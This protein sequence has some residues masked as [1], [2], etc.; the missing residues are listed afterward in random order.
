[1]LTVIIVLVLVAALTFIL[2]KK[3]KTADAN[4]T[5]IPDVIETK[6]EIVIAEVKEKAKKA[7]PKK[8]AAKTSA[9]KVIK[10]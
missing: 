10:K 8:A 7:A 4:K 2:V 1:M 6:A 5:S 9:K 3:G